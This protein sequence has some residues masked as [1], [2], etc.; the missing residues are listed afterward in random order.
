MG[1]VERYPNGSFCWVDLGTNDAQG[2]KA[3]YG[4]LF[5]WEFEDLPSGDQGTYSICR[6]DGR[7]V[8]G[9][10]DGAERPVWGSYIRVDDAARAT[11]RARELG[12]EVSLSQPGDG[13]VAEL[14]N[15]DGTWTW[16]E[17]T[18]GDLAAGRD[19]Y[20][21][22]FG[23][24]AED[25]PGPFPRTTFTLGDLLIGGG[26]APAPQEDPTPRWSITFWVPD[27]DQAAATAQELGGKVLLPP[28][29]IPAG[30]FTV[31]AAPQGATFIAAAVPGGAVRGV[32]GS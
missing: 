28:M 8:A 1:R 15:Q 6:L 19:F 25:A 13:L 22:L 2:A 5:G 31:V 10:Y 17:L 12:A 14:V 4:G 11:G 24:T 27:A 20:V 30:R 7:A 3:F 21:A 26:H 29:D 18:S 16:N 32:D 9:L 23:W